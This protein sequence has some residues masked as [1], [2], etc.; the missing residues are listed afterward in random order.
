MECCATDGDLE[1]T[2]KEIDHV[3]GTSKSSEFPCPTWNLPKQDGQGCLKW[4]IFTKRCR[5]RDAAVEDEASGSDHQ[6]HFHSSDV[7]IPEISGECN[8][9]K[10]EG[11]LQHDRQCLDDYVQSLL[12]EPQKLF[13][14]FLLSIDNVSPRRDSGI[15]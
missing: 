2:V 11:K 4:T 10:K 14:V 6:H 5:N 13:L 3:L 8:P 7:Q 12:L 15:V 1:C 9:E